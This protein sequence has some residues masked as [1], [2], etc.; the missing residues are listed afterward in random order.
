MTNSSRRRD[1]RAPPP[2]KTPWTA[3]L[4][5]IVLLTSL[6]YIWRPWQHPNSLSTLWQSQTGGFKFINLGLDLQGGLRVALEPDQANYTRD[7]LEKVRTIIENRVNALGVAEPTIQIQGN[8]R[9]IVELPGLS[10]AQQDN[11]R[12]VIGQAAVLEFRVVRDGAQP[13][14]P[15]GAYQLSDLGPVQATGEIIASAAPATDPQTGR[16]VVTFKT[17]PSGANKLLSFTRPNVGKLM[18]IVLDNKIQSVATIQQPLSD[19]VQI[20]GN[21]DAQQASDLALV[22]KSGS[23]PVPIKFA[24]QREIGPTLG[25]DAIRSG[26][27]AALI[28]V[29][30]VFVVLFVYYGFWFGLVGALGLLFSAVI[31]LGLLGGLGATL[32][33]PGIAGLVLTIGAAVDGNVISFERVKEELR[34]GKGIKN[35]TQAG[36][37][38]S[39]WTIIDVNLSH[40]LS[41][42]A[43]YNYATGP[44]KGFAVVLAI[45][46]IASAFSNLVFARWLM[47]ALARRR[48]FGAPQWFTAPNVDFIKAS[49]II[50]SLS[51]TLAILGG[52]VMLTRGF[53]FGVDFTSGTSITLKTNAGTTVEQVRAAV[54]TANVPGVTASGATIQSSVNPAVAGKSYS[55]KVPELQQPG[56]QALR[57]AFAKLP[58]GEVQAVDTVG[59]T[60]GAELRDQTIRA[61]L[62][63]LALIL[64]YVSFRFDF[65]FGFGSIVAVVHDVAIVMGLYALLGLEFNIST[66]A[67]ILT[68]IGYSLNDSIIVSDRIRENLRALRGRSYREIV[69]VSI[70]QTLSRTIMTSVSTMLP[71]LS[72]LVIGGEVLRDFSLALLIGILIG[73]YSSVYIVAPM[74]VFYENW[75]ARRK[76][77]GTPSKA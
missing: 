20:S 7:D 29:G 22:L 30:L 66:V 51:I 10:T 54:G 65:A 70:N 24:E 71:L 49:P 23:L 61:V 77:G 8:N 5:L 60:V 55:V 67:A 62:L 48:N 13:S 75:K 43:L 16:W 1:R 72:L 4:L 21:F 76:S 15:G 39:L 40:L 14:G 42:L 28:G 46:V 52:V 69:N 53:D 34:R 50:T 68:L 3:I 35:A 41:A 58:G 32:T 9:V 37:G 27:L 38:H 31:I 33:L 2:S 64:I 57:A 11:A 63:G 19:N 59:P 17:T 45:G 18:A 36:Y 56:V 74:V 12:R 26:A 73:T 44:V 47:E 6:A 25:A